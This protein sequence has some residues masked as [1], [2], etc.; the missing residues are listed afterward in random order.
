MSDDVVVRFK[1]DTSELN[2]KLD[3]AVKSV[4]DSVSKLGNTTGAESLNAKIRE[5]SES[6]KKSQASAAEFAA[7]SSAKIKDLELEIVGL[8]SKLDGVGRGMGDGVSAGAATMQTAFLGIAAAAS[9]HVFSGMIQSSI[10]LADN[11]KD[12][13]A[14]SG[15]TVET[16]SGFK[17]A[18]ESSGASLEAVAMGI[19]GISKTIAEHGSMLKQ[20]GVDT[21]DPTDAMIQLADV[22][23]AVQDPADRSALAMKL[24][25]KSGVEMLPM[26]MEGSAGLREMVT[27]GTELSGVTTEMSRRADAF[28]DSMGT[29]RAGISG[30]IARIADGMLPALISMSEAFQLDVNSS[31]EMAAAGAMLGDVFRV[32]VSAALIVKDAFMVLGDAVYHVIA[33]VGSAM[34]GNFSQ[35]SAELSAIGTNTIARA[36]NLVSTINKMWSEIQPPKIDAPTTTPKAP[37]LHGILD[38]M[39]RAGKGGGEKSAIPKMEEELQLKRIE[40]LESQHRELTKAEEQ[41]F[42]AEKYAIASKGSKD[43]EALHK[44]LEDFK[45][46]TLRE[47]HKLELENGA[48]DIADKKAL[49]LQQIAIE[50]AAVRQGV[51]LK[52]IEKTQELAFLLEFSNRRNA[53]EIQAVQERIAIAEK[54]PTT[55]PVAVRKMKEELLALER[56]HVLEVAKI[57]TDAAVAVAEEEKKKNAEMQKFADTAAK[58]IQDGFANF[59]I[60]PFKNGLKGM[61]ESFSQ[62]LVKM[63]AQAAAAKIMESIFPAGSGGGG[64]GGGI[65]AAI[66][67]LMGGGRESGGYT[68]ANTIYQVGENNKPEIFQSGGKQYLIAGDAG[69]VIPNSKIGGAQ[70]TANN[71]SITVNSQNGNPEEIRRAVSQSAR[72]LMAAMSQSQRYA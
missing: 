69:A 23:V 12:L 47:S 25:G 68:N 59:L 7:S 40:M 14:K 4:A 10:E 39:P 66:G 62:M 44:K 33:A 26:L 27:Q 56:K 38:K 30:N 45:L 72:E 16:L 60:D 53:I 70:N 31:G 8:N 57:R 61:L 36:Q 54:D 65:M 28:N 2:G 18:A 41:K 24:F 1:A 5:L 55:S 52:T 19:K 49:A 21:K 22:F 29:M 67:G 43:S 48:L 34:V 15:A 17:L 50:E 13:S 37:N 11:L 35:A 63:A 51:A 64:A 9:V 3:S 42:W 20:L 6:F 32:V 46:A 58:N 71:M